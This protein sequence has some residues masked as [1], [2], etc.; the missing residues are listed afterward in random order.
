MRSQQYE[1]NDTQSYPFSFC[2]VQFQTLCKDPKPKI[3]EFIALSIKKKII[4]YNWNS[5]FAP[6]VWEDGEVSGV[7]SGH[8][9]ELGRVG[10]I[11]ISM[12]EEDR[13]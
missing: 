4:L 11:V 2:S 12:V 9:F 3:F 8:E 1:S 13:N 5:I 6:G 7:I 10:K